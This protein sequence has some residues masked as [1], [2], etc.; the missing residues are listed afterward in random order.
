MLAPDG[1]LLGA[2]AL[3][4]GDGRAHFDLDIALADPVRLRDSSLRFVFGDGSFAVATGLV[5]PKIATDPYHSVTNR[6][7]AECRELGTR[8]PDARVLEIGA[9]ARSGHVRR[10]LV[11]PMH[12]VGLDILPGE[13]TDIVGDAHEL[14]RILE[15][16][17][18]DALFSISTFE[19]LAMP[20]KAVL[21]INRVLKP[22]GRV[23]IS[24]H[25]AFPLHEQ[26]WDFWRFSDMA[27]HA[28]FNER[29]GFRVVETA[30]GERASVVADLL[31]AV[32]TTLELQP[33]YIGSLVLAEKIA[34]TE[35]TWPVDVGHLTETMYPE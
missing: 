26:P 32:T 28:L 5:H 34:D 15:P 20:W 14:S 11:A 35:L 1:A 19:H 27:W 7:W 16:A 30:L 22:G 13:N 31:H 18:F 24:S 12:Y 17:S 33:A 9:R 2:Q 6:F 8:N 29:T 10:E 4:P 23:L 3:V 21:E 25:Q